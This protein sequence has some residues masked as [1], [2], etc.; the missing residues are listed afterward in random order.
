MV[1]YVF[2][3]LV[4]AAVC[5]TTLI[6][7]TAVAGP[8]ERSCQLLAAIG[9]N[10]PAAIEVALRDSVRHWPE[11]NRS[12]LIER[13]QKLVGELKFAGGN[14]YRIAKFGDDIEEHLLVLRLAKGEVAG[15]RIRYEWGPKEM[16]MVTVKFE[17]VYENYVKDQFLPSAL[18]IDC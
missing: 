12:K 7:G 9:G 10:S 8:T 4:V 13:L 3:A 11:A 1:R 2:K 15:M 16:T 17:R 18:K 14:V 6:G 5:M